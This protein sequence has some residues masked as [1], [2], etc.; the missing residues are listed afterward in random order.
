VREHQRRA[1]N[2]NDLDKARKSTADL[3]REQREEEE[4][5]NAEPPDLD[6]PVPGAKPHKAAQWDER[7]GCWVV[8]D[9]RR[10]DWVPYP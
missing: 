3:L 6:K 10:N 4:A 2:A 8:W 1:R 5:A 7:Q 9:K